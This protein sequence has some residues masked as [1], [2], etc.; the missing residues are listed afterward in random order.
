MIDELI[1]NKRN[2][3][4]Y[5]SFYRTMSHSF[6]CFA[7]A[8]LEKFGKDENT[9]CIK[10]T[11]EPFAAKTQD[12]ENIL[13]LPHPFYYNICQSLELAMKGFL[14]LNGIPQEEIRHKYNHNLIK[15]KEKCVN[16]GFLFDTNDLDIIEKFNKMNRELDHALRY[17]N[18]CKLLF[19]DYEYAF[20]L[21]KKLINVL[22]KY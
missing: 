10:L 20:I 11:I 19:P 7:K 15:L 22:P 4:P 5:P 21:I 12:A 17:P 1:D 14:S 13:L 8:G 18:A 6:Y 2:T 16:E 9:K 3:E